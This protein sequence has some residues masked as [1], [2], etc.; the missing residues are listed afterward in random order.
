MAE[1]E[2]TAGCGSA[3]AE[4]VGSAE[5]LAFF[6]KGPSP[7][8]FQGE[9]QGCCRTLEGPWLVPE[10]SYGWMEACLVSEKNKKKT[11]GLMIKIAF[12]INFRHFLF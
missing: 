3:A 7:Q 2:P 4:L 12:Q 10:G 6:E 1:L 11:R 8:A 5:G 9:T